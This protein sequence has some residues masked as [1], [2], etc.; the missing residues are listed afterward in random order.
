MVMASGSGTTSSLTDNDN[1]VVLA[2][3]TDTVFIGTESELRSLKRKTCVVHGR[4]I[5]VFYHD[6]DMFA[7]DF[8][9]YRKCVK[10]WPQR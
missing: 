3:D 1:V 8:H 6:A 4:K 7:M 5:T 10:L 9:C 2:D